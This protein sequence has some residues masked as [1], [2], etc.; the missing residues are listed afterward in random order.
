MPQDDLPSTVSTLSRATA[1][2]HSIW[3]YGAHVSRADPAASPASATQYVFFGCHCMLSA[4]RACRP[5]SKLMRPQDAGG[6]TSPSRHLQASSACWTDERAPHR[7]TVLHANDHSDDVPTCM[8]PAATVRSTST[9]TASLLT[10]LVGVGCGFSSSVSSELLS[11]R[12]C[13]RNTLN[14]DA[15]V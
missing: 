4:R 3:E 13:Y 14:I 2:A 10:Y 5:M 11:C 6:L 15:V 1:C 9:S 12:L 7:S 8:V